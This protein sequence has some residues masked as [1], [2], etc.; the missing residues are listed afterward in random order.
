[1]RSTPGRVGKYE[2]KAVIAR[3]A[4]SVVYDGWDTNIARRVAIKLIP[5]RHSDDEDTREALARFKRGAQAAGQLNHRNI[6]SV[7]DY[8]ETDDS[9]YLVM[10]FIEGPTLKALFDNN[11]R[12]TAAEISSIVGGILDALQYS[13]DRK[14][15]HRDMKPANVM[16]TA[17][18]TVK[19]TDFGIARLED[20][21]MTQAGMVIGTPAYMSPEQFL[22]EKVD[23]RTDIYST[24]VLLYHILTG[25]R[26]YEGTLATIM[27]KVLY[28]APLL[29]SRLS[30]SV[31]PALDSVVTRAMARKRE[32]RFQT[33][34]DFKS[35]LMQALSG[36][37]TR[38]ARL[39]PPHAKR[40]P[41]RT[42]ARA[43]P[44]EIIFAGLAV[45]VIGG[46]AAIGWHL[47]REPD[48]FRVSETPSGR[49]TADIPASPPPS[50]ARNPSPPAEAVA[51]PP[52]PS[53]ST[54]AIPKPAPVE[55]RDPGSAA[56]T[57]T[58]PAPALF[59]P[60]VR[61]AEPDTSP[62]PPTLAPPVGTTR[63]AEPSP[64]PVTDNVPERKPPPR[65]T[66]PRIGS[67]ESAPAT[68]VPDR[69]TVPP[70]PRTAESFAS[71]ANRPGP[72]TPPASDTATDDALR[73]L[74][75]GAPG[76]SNPPTD[77]V[78]PAPAYPTTSSSP[79]GLLCQSLTA[80][81]AADL[82]LDAAHGM[83]VLG[84]TSGSAAAIAGIRQQDVI[85][86]IN[87]AEVN[88]LSALRRI[89]SD[90]PAGVPVP[91]E[92]FRHGNRQV[93]QL[94]VDSIRR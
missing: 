37:E 23:L 75:N 86:K 70:S 18:N 90:A 35:E 71:P 94:Q 50:P 67:G 26:P 72:R 25:E 82:G 9:A 6:V 12:F 59:P 41:S 31:T 81:S 7:Y 62:V 76:L 40:T 38:R 60:D 65:H 8:G 91:V 85:L 92:I 83:V 34:S 47:L 64:P 22:G 20:S 88:N 69:R 52:P 77:L 48:T 66:G 87:G 63:N 11:R 42:A 79:I 32:D 29:P 1:V 30:T 93:V 28:G 36:A 13:H 45:V 4:Q 54:E 78:P 24:G 43:V 56:T 51:P 3:T 73:R 53:T 2:L 46:A 89:A 58:A 10:E 15:V 17:D 21:E 68:A 19:I 61:P 39:S 49:G 44:R 80:D 33:A 16:L 14:V 74:R 55:Q 5:I 84:V 27:H 57:E